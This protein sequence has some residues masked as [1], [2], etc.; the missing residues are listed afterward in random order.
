MTAPR[1]SFLRFPSVAA[2]FSMRV[3]LFIAFSPQN[4]YAYSQRYCSHQSWDPCSKIPSYPHDEAL[5]LPSTVY[6]VL[7][8]DAL[9]RQREL[10]VGSQSIRNKATW[11]HSI[12][13]RYPWVLVSA[14]E[15]HSTVYANGRSGIYQ[16]ATT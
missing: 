1:L 3:K 16:V 13:C 6:R 10:L 4:C 8:K 15:C 14:T 12:T 11:Y 2:V 5:L 7:C 9:V